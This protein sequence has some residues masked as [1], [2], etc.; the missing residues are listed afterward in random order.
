MCSSDLHAGGMVL[1]KRT[2]SHPG[3]R[4]GQAVQGCG[5]LDRDG[6]LDQFKKIHLHLAIL[7][8]SGTSS[9]RVGKKRRCTLVRGTPPFVSGFEA[10]S[11]VPGA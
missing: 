2:A 5:L 6:F 1:V 10:V 3:G 8:P 4:N 7:V 9:D 11:V